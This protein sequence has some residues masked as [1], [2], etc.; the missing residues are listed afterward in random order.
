MELEIDRNGERRSFFPNL[1][2]RR[3]IVAEYPAYESLARES[4]DER[5]TTRLRSG[6]AAQEVRRNK[7]TSKHDACLY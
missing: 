4:T 3:R 2:Y 5:S 7:R 1:R 6:V